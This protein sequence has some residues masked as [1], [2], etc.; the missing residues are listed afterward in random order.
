[1]DKP[2]P[3]TNF[4]LAYFCFAVLLLSLSALFSISESSILGMNKLRLRIR[5]KAGN[6]SAIRLTK[7]LEQKDVL[8][9][10][11]LAAN[12]LVN[13]L[14]S[15]LITIL[16]I[17]FFGDKGVVVATGLATVLLLIFGE[18]IPKTVSTRNPDVIAYT[19]SFFVTIIVTIFKPVAIFFT[20]I[21]RI[22]LRILGLS[23]KEP[24]QSF[25]EEEI[26]T[27]LDIGEESGILEKSENTMMNRVFKF[28]D[29]AAQ[30]IMVP[31]TKIVAL[32]IDA[33]YEEIIKTAKESGFSRFPVYRVDIDHIVGIVYIKD[34]LS[35]TKICTQGKKD[36][37]LQTFMRSPLFVLGAKKMS[38]V[39]QLLYE[40]KQSLAIVVDEYSGTDGLV[41]QEDIS[42][43]I[44]GTV[45]Q[46]ENFHPEA[47]LNTI[48]NIDDFTLDGKTLLADIREKFRLP[49][50]SEIHDTL[51]GWIEEKL[52][53]LP[54]AGDSVFAHEYKFVVLEMTERRVKEVRI[55][56]ENHTGVVSA[57]NESDANIASD[58]SKED[59]NTSEVQK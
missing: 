29:L 3:G 9:N 58:N 25:S 18:I 23:T 19:L 16:S 39:Q 22:I 45:E 49:L 54:N 48:T 59:E 37:R 15:S 1:M 40:N 30:E 44:F 11:L 41:S 42:R 56:R 14:F 7:L 8:I 26:K 57:N 43:E 51:G 38:S 47:S 6:K 31:R 53:A 24:K 52:D 28:N 36:F 10:T 21:A 32:P 35:Y 20:G 34:L 17:R 5:K 50:D 33:S 4:Y 12:D 13:I 2:P 46:S 27:V 55:V